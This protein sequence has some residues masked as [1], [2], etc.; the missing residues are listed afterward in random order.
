MVDLGRFEN[1]INS[2]PA[3]RRQFF[4]DPVGVLRKEGI[5]MSAEQ[6]QRLREA[7]AQH[8]ATKP[9][10]GGSTINEKIGIIMIGG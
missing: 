3:L 5:I 8:T 10:V 4:A 7:I 6:A 9:P 2:E 1:R